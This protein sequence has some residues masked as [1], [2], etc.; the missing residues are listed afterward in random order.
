MSS[1][2]I[3]ASTGYAVSSAT[4]FGG[5]FRFSFATIMVASQFLLISLYLAA[6]SH[7][8]IA[9]FLLP[10]GFFFY[11]H[12]RS[13]LFCTTLNVSGPCRELAPDGDYFGMLLALW[14]AASEKSFLFRMIVSCLL[15]DFGYSSVEQ[16][17]LLTLNTVS[18]ERVFFNYPAGSG[19]GNESCK[20]RLDCRSRSYPLSVSSTCSAC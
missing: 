4:F 7:K 16:F 20:A 10:F 12:K 8:T 2:D 11:K 6:L 15:I 1:F 9:C 5:N 19:L 17:F 13:D 14:G 18:W 3:F